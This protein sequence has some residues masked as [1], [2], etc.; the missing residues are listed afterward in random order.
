M[1]DKWKFASRVSVAVAGFAALVLLLNIALVLSPGQ[2]TGR[3]VPGFEAAPAYAAAPEG[4]GQAIFEQKCQAC[5]TIGAG[6]AVGPDL[7]GITAQRDRKWL[8]RFIVAPQQVIAEGDPIA[9]QL[10]QEY[11]L[12]MPNM[13]LSEPEAE[14]VLS[15]IESQS[16][17]T[18]TTPTP[19]PTPTAT[20][21]PVAAGDAAGIGERLFNG[22]TALRNGGA[23]CISC[24][25]V[26]GIGTLGGGTMAKDLSDAYA[27]LGEQGLTSLLK[28]TPFPIMIGLYRERPLADDEIAHL[29]AFL[30]ETGAAESKP[31]QNQPIFIAA[32]A[33]GF[34][35]LL[36]VFQLAWR[37]RL[38]GVR[39]PLLRG[40]AR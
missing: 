10:V 4:Q 32:G 33:G 8:I 39:Q 6:R 40:G 23:A 36:G 14:D 17:G 29:I 9:T 12:P 25:N 7:K 2:K 34:L 24:H 30:R 11:G 5:H 38:S 26:S 13:G 1:T 18:A 35:I 20:S 3:L 27:R 31:A 28:T 16:A 22:Q 37:R 15:Y 21:V 19:A